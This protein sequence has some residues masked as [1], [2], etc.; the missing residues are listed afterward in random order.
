MRNRI[1]EC[2]RQIAD[3]Q[4]HQ[5]GL[6]FTRGSEVMEKIAVCHA[7]VVGHRLQR[8]GIGPVLDQELARRS[9]RFATGF[10]GRPTS[11]PRT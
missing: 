10:I 5:L 2:Q 3:H 7:E 9:Q 1:H 8:D 4:A 6:Q 11:P